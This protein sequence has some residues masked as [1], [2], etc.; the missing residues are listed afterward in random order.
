MALKV[1]ARLL[2]ALAFTFLVVGCASTETREV[3]VAAIEIPGIPAPAASREKL[4]YQTLLDINSYKGSTFFTFVKDTVKPKLDEYATKGFKV[5]D[6][7]KAIAVLDVVSKKV[8]GSALRAAKDSATLGK[9]ADALHAKGELV[10]LY[11]LPDKIKAV[12]KSVDRFDLSTYYALA[13]GGGVAIKLSDVNYYY[14]V[15]YGTGKTPKDERTGR[16]FGASPLRNADD[17]SDKSYLRDLEQYVRGS[18]SAST[19]FFRTILETLTNT[20]A[21]GYAKLSDL[22]QSVATDFLAIYTAEQD[23]HLMANLKTHHW[24][25]ALL[26]VTLISALHAGQEKVALFFDGQLKDRVPNQEKCGAPRD[27]IRDASMIDYWQFT[28][29]P[30][31]ESCSRSGINITKREF[32]GIGMEISKYE[33]KAN[34]DLVKNI[35]RHLKGVKT[36]GNVFE[37]ISDY[38]IS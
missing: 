8:S 28:S 16:S 24:D 36:G 35:E 14:N 32:R 11:T 18:G 10:T 12:N 3:S 27:K 19:D 1:R 26:E 20:D 17:I 37:A 7:K 29:N 30:D 34:P 23:R 4:G 31:P 38:L 33:R 21:R 6:G 13:S 9:I 5:S 22:G 15:N 25:V 2:Y